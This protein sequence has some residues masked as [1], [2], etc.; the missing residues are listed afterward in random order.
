M[1][2][3]DMIFN[4]SCCDMIFDMSC[5]D[6]IFHM[7]YCAI[8]MTLLCFQPVRD[9]YRNKCEFTVGRCGNGEGKIF[10]FIHL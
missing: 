2:C 10:H 6:M 7:S 4:M 3:C 1:S 5:I 8:V 9:G